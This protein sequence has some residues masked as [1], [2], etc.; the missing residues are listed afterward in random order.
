MAIYNKSM[1]GD[2]VLDG[3]LGY[4]CIPVPSKNGIT[5]WYDIC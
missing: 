4:Y 3:L 5:I 1:G 2:D